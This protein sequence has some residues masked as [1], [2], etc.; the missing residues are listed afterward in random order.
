MKDCDEDSV[1]STST[2][3]SEPE[4]K[5]CIRWIY[6][7][8]YLWSCKASMSNS[9]FK[10]SVKIISCPFQQQIVP[11]TKK[12]D[13]GAR[14]ILY[15]LKVTK[16]IAIQIIRE[17]I[18]TVREV[19][20]SHNLGLASW[21]NLRNII[22]SLILATEVEAAVEPVEKLKVKRKD[23]V[24]NWP[25]SNFVLAVMYN[26]ALSN[27]DDKIWIKIICKLWHF[28]LLLFWVKYLAIYKQGSSFLELIF[29]GNR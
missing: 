20:S 10:Y 23:V 7:F 28:Y 4:G 15:R 22:V 14:T 3:I 6:T 24:Y 16:K 13:T 25:I 9:D 2:N 27:I 17:E 21:N 29:G 5:L 1:F 26:D 18:K 12:P 8:T 19:G 11:T